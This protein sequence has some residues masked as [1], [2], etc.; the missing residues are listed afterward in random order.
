[1]FTNAKRI[2]TTGIQQTNE[3][4]K[5]EHKI[6][7]Q[8]RI[9]Y[10]FVALQENNNDIGFVSCCNNLD[11]HSNKGTIY[12]GMT[13]RLLIF[14]AGDHKASGIKVFIRMVA[15]DNLYRIESYI[16]TFE[17]YESFHN[18]LIMLLRYYSALL[19]YS[20][21]VLCIAT[22]GK[23]KNQHKQSDS[24]RINMFAVATR[25]H[26]SDRR[27]RRRIETRK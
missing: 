16:G 5:K 9:Y 2:R 24:L 15:T 25:R 13:D 26:A 17:F 10:L 12:A 23:K 4:R 19:S 14:D 21:T 27:V 7:I 18:W 8:L 6:K 1:L 22:F 20:G 3:Q 11:F